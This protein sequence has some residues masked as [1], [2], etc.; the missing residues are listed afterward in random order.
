MNSLRLH[1]DGRK[2]SVSHD[3]FTVGRHSECDLSIADGRLSREHLK[4]EKFGDVFAAT[5]LNSSNG[6][7]IN[8]TKL[9]APTTLKNGDT[10]SL[11]GLEMKVE[12]VA[13]A[14][15]K[16]DIFDGFD[17]DF[18]DS[19]DA[20]VP[21]DDAPEKIAAAPE[22]PKTPKAASASNQTKS[23][24]T[25]KTLLILAPVFALILVVAVVGSLLYFG[26]KHIEVVKKD[27]D[28]IYSHQADN[29]PD[30]DE[31]ENSNSSGKTTPKPTAT[32]GKTIDDS[33]TPKDNPPPTPEIT[34]DAPTPKNQPDTT[35]IEQNSA[36]FLRKIAQND[37][38]AFLTS[39]QAQTVNAKIKQF[40]NSGD[41]AD[42]LKSAKS[43]AS[44]IQSLATA[45]NLKPQFVAVAALAKLGGSRGNVLQTAQGMADVLDKLSIQLGSELADDSL[46]TVAVYDQGAAG[47]FLKTRNMLQ[48]LSNKFPESSRTIRTIWFLHKNNKISDA[49][50]DFAVRFLAIGT[51]TQNP[52]DFNVNAEELKLN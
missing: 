10:L 43:N 2:I 47:D 1:F 39:E 51:I 4:I 15:V 9:T 5:D 44:A 45:K 16:D 17:D 52:K 34:N 32:S 31:V 41:L 28:F 26:R 37:P 49:E 24:S 3:V 46:L 42:N 21:F 11:G 27:D 36:S 12:I 50:F 48:D 23:G 7:L 14:A 8:R 18:D 19:N 35:K 20:Q 22:K 25:S 40:A 38:K 6:T 30:N 13:D 29:S 33:P